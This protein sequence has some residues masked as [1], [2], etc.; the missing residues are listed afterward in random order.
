MA[1]YLYQVNYVGE[2][3]KGLVKEG[4]SSR[5]AVAQKAAKSLGGK[6]E[7]FYFAFGDFDAYMICDMP[8]HA[9]ASSLALTVNA[10][11]AVTV[12]TVVLVSPEEVDAATK[13]K[14]A[15]RAPGK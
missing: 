3:I 5:K 15:Y 2:G 13:K 10:S 8:D 4:G 7:A 6:V 14:M 9:S 1:K 12:K 11:G